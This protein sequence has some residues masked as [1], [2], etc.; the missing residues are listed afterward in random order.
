MA[1]HHLSYQDM[2][3]YPYPYGLYQ[4]PPPPHPNYDAH[5]SIGSL[6]VSDP[7][8]AAKYGNPYL[9]A[10]PPPEVMGNSPQM[11]P[12]HYPYATMGPRPSSGAGYGQQ[13]SGFS[14]MQRGSKGG[15][16]NYTGTMV[17]N[18]KTPAPTS[19]GQ[20]NNGSNSQYIVSPET[21]AKADA[22]MATHV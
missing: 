11:T 14:S 5:L 22:A 10:M 6:N 19:N 2:Q 1:N 17:G 9:R 21:D 20:I 18:G 16:V 7:R 8:Y 4:P 12:R 13:P 3:G 15:N